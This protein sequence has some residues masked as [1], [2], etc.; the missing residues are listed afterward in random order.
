MTFLTF[1]DHGISY[2]CSVHEIHTNIEQF[3]NEG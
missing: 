1:V 2:V 3:K